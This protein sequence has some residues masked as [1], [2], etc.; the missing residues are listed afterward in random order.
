MD[1]AAHIL[2]PLHRVARGILQTQRFRATRLLIPLERLRYAVSSRRRRSSFE[3]AF[4][5]LAGKGYRVFH[6]QLRPRADGEVRGM[7]RVADQH[8][9]AMMPAGIA[10]AR[11]AYPGL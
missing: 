10:H 1:V 5:K 3:R 4:R 7:R 11:E 8:R 6:G 9:V 2:E